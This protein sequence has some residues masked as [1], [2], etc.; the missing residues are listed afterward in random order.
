MGAGYSGAHP[1]QMLGT[2][3][4]G[5]QTAE[6][7]EMGGMHT[8]HGNSGWEETNWGCTIMG[9]IVTAMSNVKFSPQGTIADTLKKYS[10]LMI[11]QDLSVGLI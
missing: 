10:M 3:V 7:D 8:V 4:R 1:S 2:Q 11:P 5:I 6:A 9:P